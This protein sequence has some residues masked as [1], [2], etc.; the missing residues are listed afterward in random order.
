MAE[1]SSTPTRHEYRGDLARTPLP[2]VLG[3]IERY[4]APGTIECRRGREA[5]NIFIDGGRIIWATSN[6]L[7]DSLGCRLVEQGK[8]PRESLDESVRRLRA[9]GKR[10]GAILVDMNLLEPKELFVAVREQVQAIVWSIFEWSEGEV[11]FRAGREGQ[12]ELIKLNIPIRQAIL[13]GV[14]LVRDAK[15]LVSRMGTRTTVMQRA[16]EPEP[17]LSFG[18][19]EQ[20]LWS[21]IDGRKTLFDLTHTAGL[22]PSQNA[23]ILYAFHALGLMVPKAPIKVQVKTTGTKYGSPS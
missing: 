3:T 16:A 2:E 14:P 20:R 22:P 21:A 7:A 6:S 13:Q 12:A 10:Q 23:K 1:S 15:L 8:I 5:K 17:S 11:Q 19:D 4:S 18:P 9:E